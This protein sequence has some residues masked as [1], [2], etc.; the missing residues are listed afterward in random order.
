MA[1]LQNKPPGQFLQPG[2][3]IGEKPFGYDVQG[4]KQLQLTFLPSGRNCMAL[5]QIWLD[6][7]FL[8]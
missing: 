3:F 5:C 1:G 4:H 7:P 6:H 8:A 2:G